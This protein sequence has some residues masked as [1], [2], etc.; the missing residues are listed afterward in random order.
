MNTSTALLFL[1]SATFALLFALGT[2]AFK[3]ALRAA[4][5][6]LGH[7]ISLAGLYL[8]LHAQ[9]LSAIQVLVYAGAV[10]VLF[11]FV[12]MLIGQDALE[13][14]SAPRGT[15]VR[16]IG[17]IALLLVTFA[18]AGQLSA[19]E[20]QPGIIETCTGADC[21]QFGGVEA[22]AHAIYTDA[23]IPFEMLSLLLTVAVVAAIAIAKSHSA[24]EKKAIE[25]VIKA[26][27]GA[28]VHPQRPRSADPAPAE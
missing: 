18:L 13:T 24:E 16:S 17:A 6:L 28:G 5:S 4:V 15:T 12:I 20:M 26:E 9:L 3:N 11:V 22:V 27:Q 21:R 23:A 14:K 7:V 19:V 25:A 8:S 2:V 1:V 10:V